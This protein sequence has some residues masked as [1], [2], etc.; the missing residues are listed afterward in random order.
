ME[1]DLART[2]VDIAELLSKEKIITLREIE[3]W[4]E[5]LSPVWNTSEMP[6]GLL[7]VPI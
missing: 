3:L 4:V 5:H 1:G 7:T 2:L 6:H